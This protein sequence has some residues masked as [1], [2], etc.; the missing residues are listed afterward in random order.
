MQ[1]IF[2]LHYGQAKGT[3]ARPNYQMAS[4]GNTRQGLS[5]PVTT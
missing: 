2:F 4:E 1:R 3:N 5:P